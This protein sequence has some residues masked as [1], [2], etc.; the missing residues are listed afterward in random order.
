M[1]TVEGPEKKVSLSA[2]GTTNKDGTSGGGGNIIV[3]GDLVL[4][5]NE[6]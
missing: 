2:K 6:K 1:F 3:N 5:G 4:G